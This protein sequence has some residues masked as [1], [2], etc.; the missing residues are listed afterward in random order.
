LVR[1]GYQ[2]ERQVLTGASPVSVQLPKT[3]NR[4]DRGRFFRPLV[5]PPYLKNAWH[6]EVD[7]PWLYLKGWS[8][9]DFDEALTALFGESVREL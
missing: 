7:L 9:N 5:L 4:A 1:N 3:H 2:P 8:T 6:P